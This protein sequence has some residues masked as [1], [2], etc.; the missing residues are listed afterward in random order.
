MGG[1]WRMAA[2]WAEKGSAVGPPVG[3]QMGRRAR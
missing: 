2:L 3:A 1:P